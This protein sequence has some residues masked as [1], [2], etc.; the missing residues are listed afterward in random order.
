MALP[1]ECGI[2]KST[3][4]V[5]PPTREVDRSSLSDGICRRMTGMWEHARSG[6]DW[7]PDVGDGSICSASK[8]SIIVK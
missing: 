1:P 3:H 2:D 5:G 6:E 8:I 7:A 4:E